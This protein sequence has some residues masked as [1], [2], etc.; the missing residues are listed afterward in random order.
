[1]VKCCW[2]SLPRYDT[3]ERGRDEARMQALQ[4]DVSLQLSV[5]VPSMEGDE[6]T[7]KASERRTTQMTF[8]LTH[9]SRV[10]MTSEVY[11]GRIL[12]TTVQFDGYFVVAGNQREDFAKEL[13]ALVERFAI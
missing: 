6:M 11:E 13:Q 7:G 3:P 4:I 2:K 8:D 9:A 12:D 10:V 1:M 5:S